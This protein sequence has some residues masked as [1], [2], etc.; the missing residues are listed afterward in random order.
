MELIGLAVALPVLGALALLQIAVACAAPLG[1]LVWGGAHRVLPT[2]LRWASA[3]SVLLYAGFA[4][5]LVD[6]AGTSP[7]AVSI[8]VGWV[9]LAYFCLGILLNL[10]SRSVIERAV[11]TPVC[12][13]LAAATLAIV[14]R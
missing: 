4:W 9:L 12:V 11:M 13:V 6:R 10:A 2:R 8:T 1:R 14:V 7:S 3:A 5:V